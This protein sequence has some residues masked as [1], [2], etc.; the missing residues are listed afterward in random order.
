MLRL[1]LR[2]VFGNHF[3]DQEFLLDALANRF[4]R[5]WRCHPRPSL[6]HSLRR[7]ETRRAKNAFTVAKNS[8]NL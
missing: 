7:D 8:K 2:D 4:E 5:E 3:A 6:F 1:P